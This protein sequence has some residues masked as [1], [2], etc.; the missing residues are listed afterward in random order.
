MDILGRFRQRIVTKF[1][2]LI[3][4]DQT[5]NSVALK[6]LMKD[7]SGLILFATTSG[8]IASLNTQ[9]VFAKGAI[10]IK[11]DIGSGTTGRYENIGTAAVSLFS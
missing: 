2:K 11:T 3:G 4:G 10:V 8:T 6:V 1:V 7:S 5:V 9:T